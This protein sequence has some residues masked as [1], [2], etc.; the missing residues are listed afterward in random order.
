M[1]RASLRW[2][3]ALAF[4]VLA[5]GCSSK[6]PVENDPGEIDPP[7]GGTTQTD[8]PSTTPDPDPGDTSQP[9]SACKT[10][11]AS[12]SQVFAVDTGVG[13]FNLRGTEDLR[14][15]VAVDAKGNAYYTRGAAG[16]FT[17]T[18][19]SP[20]GVVVY[21]VPFG[22]VVATDADGN[23][24]VAGAFSAPLDIGLGPMIPAAD[25][26][27]FVA[28]LA[29]DGK[30]V[31]ARAL[32]M[33]PDSVRS[34]AVARDGRIAVS[35]EEM[36][37]I[38]L[39][40]MAKVLF[41]RSFAGDLAFD[42][43]GNLIVG[44]AFSGAIDFGGGMGFKTGGD[45]DGFVVKLDRSGTALWSYQIGD[46]SLPVTL[47]PSSVVVSTPTRQLIAAV[48]VGPKDEIVIAGRFDD[49][50]KLFG[51]DY[52]ANLVDIAS[53]SLRSGGFVAAFDAAGTVMVK[54]VRLGIDGFNDV[55]VDAGGDIV[56]TGA[57]LVDTSAP[58]RD[59]LLIR[60]DPAGTAAFETTRHI[61]MGHAVA[62]DPCGNVLWSA[63]VRRSLDVPLVAQLIKLAP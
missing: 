58:F 36:G 40:A 46:A 39:D 32:G 23:A 21:Q 13:G 35:G 3:N 54:N 31:F 27:V 17:L 10:S 2:R 33:C 44:G 25:M 60:L 5:V 9:P 59:P 26:D 4:A 12:G 7:A 51:T 41:T 29:P 14:S 6:H 56:V 63:S 22:E 62:V 15:E 61:G 19:Y 11:A 47:V 57:A 18:K 16:S 50:V 1:T 37:T 55:A 42:S 34:I 8:P 28:K 38:V 48:A 52:V 30:P 49:D 45:L 43:A 20:A 53:V 24:Y